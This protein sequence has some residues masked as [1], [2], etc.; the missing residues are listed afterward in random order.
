MASIGSEDGLSVFNREVVCFL[1]VDRVC[2][3]PMAQA[4]LELELTERKPPK[5]DVG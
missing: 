3:R 4:G 5:L 2:A 1:V